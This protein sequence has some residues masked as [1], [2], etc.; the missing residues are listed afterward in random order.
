V[1]TRELR[2]ESAQ[3]AMRQRLGAV[4]LEP[5]L[6]SIAIMHAA[7]R[8]QCDHEQWVSVMCLQ[9]VVVHVVFSSIFIDRHFFCPRLA[10]NSSSHSASSLLFD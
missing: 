9:R 10:C 6:A 1:H 7:T 4:V 3:M 8:P 2:I 5:L